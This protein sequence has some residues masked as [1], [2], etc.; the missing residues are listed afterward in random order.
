[1]RSAALPL[2]FNRHPLYARG[3]LLVGDSGGMVS[4][5]NGQGIG[6]ALEARLAATAALALAHPEGPRRE[7][8]P[9][10]YP[11]EMEPPLGPLLPAGQRGRRRGLQPFRVPA[12]LNRYVMNSPLSCTGRLL[13]DLT[14]KPSRDVIDHLLNTA[15]RFVPAPR[16]G[17]A[18]KPLRRAAR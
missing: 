14:D 17:R 8:A 6:Q 11:V 5:W 4:P 15:I 2:G 18:R 10:G 13:A 1:M 3:L 16:P 9:R 7:Q 12:V